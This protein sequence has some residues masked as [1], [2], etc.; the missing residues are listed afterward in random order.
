ML[1]VL[2]VDDDPLVRDALDGFLSAFGFET[3]SAASSAEALRTAGTFEPDAAVVDWM[4]GES[5]Y[6]SHV[7]ETLRSQL[8][9]LAVIFVSGY[10]ADGMSVE[11][12]KLKRARFLSKPFKPITLAK[13]IESLVSEK[14]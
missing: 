10:H 5:T 3:E 14:R 2:V 1:K 13:T 4:L 8:P 9:D 7:A 11:I 6:G 12:G